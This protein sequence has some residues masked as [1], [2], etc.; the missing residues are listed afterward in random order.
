MS[1]ERLQSRIDERAAIKARLLEKNHLV[2][3]PKADQLFDMAWEHGHSAG[4]SEI[5]YW[6]GELSQL[7]S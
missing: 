4:E 6:I 5:D 1:S 2:N 3:H 7:V